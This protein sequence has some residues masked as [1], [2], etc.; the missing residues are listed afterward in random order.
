MSLFLQAGKYYDLIAFQ[1]QSRI[2][3]SKKFGIKNFFCFATID[4]KIHKNKKFIK[5]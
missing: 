3:L 4:K 2:K 1:D 5:N